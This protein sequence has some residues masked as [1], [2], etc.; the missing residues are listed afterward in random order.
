M[1]RLGEAIRSLQGGG[2]VLLL[3]DRT[4]STSGDL[5]MASQ[6]VTSDAVNFMLRE[7]RCGLVEVALAPD[8]LDDLGV[9]L[10]VPDSASLDHKAVAMSVDARD[11]AVPPISSEGRARTIRALADET[12][13]PEDL[14]RPGHVTPLRARAGGV[15]K[16][17]G[18]TEAAV[19]LARL[20]GLQPVAMVSPVL[21]QA[22]ARADLED[23]ED[24][25]RAHDIPV[26]SVAELIAHRRRTERLVRLDAEADLPTELGH[27][28]I[29]CYT[30]LVD[31][32]EYVAVVK[33]DVAN[34]ENVLVRVHSGCL[35]GDVLGSC[36]CD[37]G[38]QL[39]SAL[40]AIE[41]AGLGVVIYVA[42]HE[43]RGIGLANKLKAYHL[44]DEGYDTVEANEALGFEADLRDYG[45]GAQILVDLGITTMRILTNNPTK[46]VALE[47]YGLRVVERVPIEAPPTEHSRR[48][49]CT[50][51]RKMGH[52]LSLVDDES[53]QGGDDPGEVSRSGGK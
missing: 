3:D 52:W 2:F 39:Q 38:W 47:G 25:A 36:R 22:G 4:P 40:Q 45:I 1:E 51:K 46:Y 34:Q 27:F 8:R 35:T 33:G 29:R 5:V 15:L 24:L 18:H 53:P 7:A 49:L 6:F 14:V 13:R 50:K 20:A 19:D 28:R 23:L 10:L 16:R 37:C 21:D 26:V 11:L 12:T 32:D 43:G 42:R 44:Q 17:A 48:Y 30:S 41:S 31:G 9:P